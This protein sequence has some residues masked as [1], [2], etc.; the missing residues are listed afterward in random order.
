MNPKRKQLRQHQA[1]ICKQIFQCKDAI[2]GSL[3]LIKRVCGKSNCHCQ[4]G[5]KHAT[6]YLS[7]RLQGKTSMIYVPLDEGKGFLEGIGQYKKMKCLIKR[8]SAVNE[9]ILLKT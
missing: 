2:Q 3:V 1:K 6:L 8:L 4:K 9:Q 5:F 7:K